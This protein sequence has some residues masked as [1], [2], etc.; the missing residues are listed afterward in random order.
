VGGNT[1]VLL[2][3]MARGGIEQVMDDVGGD[4]FAPYVPLYFETS[5]KLV[6]GMSAHPPD[7]FAEHVF[8][9]RKRGLEDGAAISIPE[10]EHYLLFTASRPEREVPRWS[11]AV[12]L[13]EESA[14]GP[15]FHLRRVVA[16]AFVILL[17]AMAVTSLLA[18]Q[19]ATRP[20]LRL[21]SSMS[22]VG[23]G[24]LNIRLPPEPS[25]DLGA[26]VDAFN[27]MVTEVARAREKLVRTEAIRREMEIAHDLQ[28]RLLPREVQLPGFS[29]GARAQPAVEVGGDFYDVIRTGKDGFWVLIGDVSGHGLNAGLVMLMVQAAVQATV[30]AHPDRAPREIVAD[31]NRVLHENVRRR[32][33]G[34][35]YVTLLV[36][37]HVGEGRFQCA[38]AHQPLLICRR[39]GE[40]EVID[41]L[42]P[43]LG[44][45]PEIRSQVVEREFSLEPGESL[46]LITDGLVEAR[47]DT[48]Q[49]FGM[50]RLLEVIR[51]L[52][53]TAP[54]EAVDRLFSTVQEFNDDQ[55]DDMTLLLLK[56][57]ESP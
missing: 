45:V 7:A 11:T 2:G 51:S 16:S 5:R 41:T 28:T 32:M 18:I 4:D 1:G 47:N 50:D 21:A 34:D 57:Q 6:F 8:D 40:V 9:A 27:T 53:A 44:I 26:L 56:R 17:A 24:E 33:R 3:M 23:K 22:R 36:A 38:G 48:G 19:S 31:V 35:D 42:G 43:W 25:R 13:P 37:R 14:L 20:L 15:L 55:Q 30:R 12:L 52:S 39:G 46:W 49:E 10:D 29:A 54:R